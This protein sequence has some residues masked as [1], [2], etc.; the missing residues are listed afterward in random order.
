MDRLSNYAG[1]TKE[2]IEIVN[3]I[4]IFALF[5]KYIDKIITEQGGTIEC[6]RLLE[7]QVAFLRFSL[8]CYPMSTSNV[9]SILDS[10]VVLISKYTENEARLDAESL[11]CIVKLLSFPLETLSLAILSMNNYP[12]L[13]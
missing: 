12:R 4:D 3:T 8:K 2:D 13:M 5:K 7:L 9:N 10:C 1:D 6:R 11:K